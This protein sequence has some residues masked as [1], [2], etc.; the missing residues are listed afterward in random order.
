M[1]GIGG[2]HNIWWICHW[3]YVAQNIPGLF[4]KRIFSGREKGLTAS[5]ITTTGKSV[6]KLAEE[7]DFLWISNVSDFK[8]LCGKYIQNF[9]PSWMPRG[10]LGYISDGE[11]WIR[12]TRRIVSVNYLFGRP[13]ISDDF[14]KGIFTSNFRDMGNLRPSAFGLI[15]MSFR[16]PKK[17]KLRFSGNGQKCPG[18]F[19][20]TQ[21]PLEWPNRYKIL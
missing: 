11:V 12:G 19:E 6:I 2:L 8:D 7:W 10:C 20:K 13:L 14:L 15:K 3:N 5:G 18:D 16:V 21:V 9:K 4:R 1:L 17:G